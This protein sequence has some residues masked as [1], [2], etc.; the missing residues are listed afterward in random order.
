MTMNRLFRCFHRPE[1]RAIIFFYPA[2][3]RM[4]CLEVL[5]K[6]DMVF[7]LRLLSPVLVPLPFRKL[8]RIFS[9]RLDWKVLWATVL[10]SAPAVP[11]LRRKAYSLDARG[12]S[13]CLW[14]TLILRAL[15]KSDGYLTTPSAESV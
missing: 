11:D 6:A 15:R 8:T 3:S 1:D 14:T 2:S 7:S 12:F 10:C 9:S 4:Q 5:D 13:R